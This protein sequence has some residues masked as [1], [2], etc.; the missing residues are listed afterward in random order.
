MPP[1]DQYAILNHLTDCVLIVDQN[2]TILFANQNF[3]D[4]CASSS[5]KVLGRTCHAILHRV[6]SPCYG[7]C[8]PE[9]KCV[10]R[11]VFTTGLPATV[12][13]YHTLA[14][15]SKRFCRITASPIQDDD[16]TTDRI[17]CVIKDITR[18]KELED[19]LKRTLLENEAIL[20]NAPFY[21][22]YVDLEMRVITIDTYMEQ[23]IGRKSAEVR[24]RHCYEVWGQ[25][26]ETPE[27]KGREKICDACKVQYTVTDGQKYSY[28][29]QIRGRYIS[30]TSSPVKDAEGRIIGALECGLDIT[31]RKKTEF[32]LQKSEAR[33]ATLFHDNPNVMLLID[34]YTADILDANSA[35]CAYYGYDS[36]EW[37]GM[38]ISDINALAPQKILEKIHQVQ[39]N[40]KETFLFQHRLKSGELREVEVHSGTLTIDDRQLLCSTI[41]DITDQKKMEED[42]FQA[43]KM[44]A[45][46]TLAGG[47][48]HDFNNIL[49]AIQGY[50]ELAKLHLPPETGTVAREDI[51]QIISAGQRAGNLVKQILD[52]SRKTQQSLQLL[53]PH[54]VVEEVLRLMRATL[55]TSVE[56][57][58]DIDRASGAILADPTKIHQIVMN[59]C[60][61]G[62]H[63]MKDEK[64]V[65]RVSLS[66][67]TRT[68]GDSAGKSGEPVPFIVLS[69]SDT[70][71]GMDAETVDRIFEPYFTTKEMG[72]G[73]GLGLAVVHGIIE[74]YN[75]C[76]EVE[77]EPGL[78]STFRLFIPALEKDI[79]IPEKAKLLLP[80]PLGAERILIV[81]DEPLLVRINQ[82]LLENY[83]YTVTGLTDSREALAKVQAD[84]TQ[85]DLIVSDQTMP[86]LTGSELARAVLAIA[87]L[88]PII[89]CT[90]HSTVISAEDAYAM[91][92]KH[93]MCKPLVGDILARTV[94]MVLD[95]AK[96]NPSGKV[97]SL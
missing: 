39:K 59:L 68:V 96:T 36:K 10:H 31:A 26:A 73:T 95:E 48:A 91:G 60:T 86:G 42:L 2:H 6:E 81:D 38:N 11:Q 29:K 53:Q 47:V 61:N 72:K 92:I 65:L 49:S 74:G 32:A 90:G 23:L 21:L 55:P 51:D 25:Y 28:E 84:P 14:D 80:A 89:I 97:I 34:P 79:S 54:L 4:L 58:S 43:Q 44:D 7:Q 88:M 12:K 40:G 82:R 67:Q 63:A 24:G 35:A 83:G 52:F 20:N 57:Q 71:Q 27:K 18:E 62:F 13:H 64:G 66:R 70:G 45:I 1:H 69:V 50:A 76:I 56:I 75:G 93:Y 8:L 5:E 85:F 87:P 77:S 94:R 78:G 33:Y 46:G 19:A 30:V 41:H 22:S 3:Y 37:P 9:L 15:G 16:G 17:L